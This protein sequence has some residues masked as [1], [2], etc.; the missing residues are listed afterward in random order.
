MTFATLALVCA[1]SVALTLAQQPAYRQTGPSIHRHNVRASHAYRSSRKAQPPPAC[2]EVAAFA[3]KAA[4]AAMTAFNVTGL[5]LGVVCNHTVVFADG[6]GF[7]DIENKK[8][9]T[10]DTL[11]QIAS[12][13]KAFTA[14]VGLQMVEEGL[15]LN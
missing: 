6:F 5:S 14:M 3:Q 13:T 9:A 15:M 12:N 1:G 7:A 4:T 11:F 8:A 2:S 10:A